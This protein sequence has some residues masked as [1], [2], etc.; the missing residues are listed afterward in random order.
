M[1]YFEPSHP[2]VFVKQLTKEIIVETVTAY[3]AKDDAYWLKLYHFAD[4]VDT[5]VFNQ[6]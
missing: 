6:L 2:F 3:V 5:A 1:S 4:D